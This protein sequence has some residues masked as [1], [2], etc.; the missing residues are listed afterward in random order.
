MNSQREWPEKFHK[1]FEEAREVMQIAEGKII[2]TSDFVKRY[3]GK[4]EYTNTQI[5][6][7]AM[8]WT[9]VLFAECIMTGVIIKTIQEKEEVMLFYHC[10]DGIFQKG[11]EFVVRKICRT[12]DV[13]C[14]MRRISE[15]MDKI[16]TETFEFRENFDANPHISL[17]N[18]V[19]DL[20]TAALEDHSPKFLLTRKLDIV[21]NPKAIPKRYIKFLLEIL[22]P[23]DINLVCEILAWCLM[24]DYWRDKIFVYSGKG[25]NG[26]TTLLRV[27]TAFLGSE[28]IAGNSIQDFDTD[29][30]AAAE[31]RG[32][33]ANIDADVTTKQ[34]SQT[35]MLKKLSGR[36]TITVNVK[37]G[38]RITFVNPCKLLFAANILPA[39]RYDDT[40]AIWRRLH[41]IKCIRQFLGE[42]EDP[43]L[44]EK[45]TTP[46]ELSGIL[47]L[48]ISAFNVLKE[49]GRFVK[50]KSIKQSRTDYVKAS[51]P[52]HAFALWGVKYQKNNEVSNPEFFDAFLKF[53]SYHSIVPT[54][55]RFLSENFQ[56]YRPKAFKS[57][58]GKKRYWRHITIRSSFK[59]P[60][61][62]RN[63]DSNT[64][65]LN[66]DTS[67]AFPFL[68]A[69]NIKRYAEDT[70]E[71]KKYIDKEQLER[72]VTC[73]TPKIVETPK[74]WKENILEILKESDG[75]GIL[76]QE[77]VDQ[78]TR[79]KKLGTGHQNRINK[80]I[81][82]L[83]GE[84]LIYSPTDGKFKKV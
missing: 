8:R 24:P 65:C 77:I 20:K 16:K 67:D 42:K 57:R 49:R 61:E 80:A 71:W 6:A 58:G 64:S 26:K 21:F 17:K 12:I 36:D 10:E 18:G 50:E 53:C 75:E 68:F 55:Q 48:T 11:A 28:N 5:K 38:K 46:E 56:I 4:G 13:R 84:G 72:S 81:D 19:L 25:G 30:Y 63:N 31:L 83:M 39:I 79:E 54:T 2:N 14:S 44:L 51:N 33:F 3:I 9:S 47:N 29:Q 82:E 37:Y 34:L 40:D 7:D 62:T 70:E 78:I 45:L 66:S 32:K 35:G 76:R 15:V 41:E 60:D 23:D 52:I 74:S 43:D 1:K 73:V 22:Q 59:I 69:L 27:F